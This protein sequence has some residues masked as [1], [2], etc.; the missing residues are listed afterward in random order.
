MRVFNSVILRCAFQQIQDPTSREPRLEN[1]PRGL[2][3]LGPSLDS[4]PQNSEEHPAQE[5]EA[6]LPQQRLQ[7]IPDE[8]KASRKLILG[9]WLA[10][11]IPK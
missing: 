10:R 11:P 9:N 3:R 1:G 7:F 5:A 2:H 4:E 6:P 8:E